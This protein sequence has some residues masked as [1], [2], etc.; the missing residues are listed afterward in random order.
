MKAK[1]ILVVL[2][3]GVFCATSAVA[4]DS[5]AGATNASWKTTLTLGGNLNDG[6]TR[7]AKGNASLLIEGE[8]NHLGSVRAGAE[9]NYGES[10][11][12]D[13]SR[14]DTDNGKAFINAKKTLTT[15]TYGYGD[16]AASR[17]DLAKLNYRIV[18]GPGAGA[19]VVKNNRA[20]LNFEAGV[21]YLWENQRSQ[22]KDE[23]NE[24]SDSSEY[25]ALRVAERFEFKFSD[26][27]RCWQALEFLAAFEDLDDNII[28]AEVGVESDL[29]SRFSLRLVVQNKYDNQP[30]E[31]MKSNDISLIAGVSLKI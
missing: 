9:L 18:L 17:D 12:D 5:D 3:I 25:W 1:S 31:G 4:A 6:N 16:L 13:E 21:S 24:N 22:N 2:A 15:M 30:A 19:Y 27:A 7:S 28:N 23:E 29:T 11:V 26:S 8:K 14:T 10:K 20:S